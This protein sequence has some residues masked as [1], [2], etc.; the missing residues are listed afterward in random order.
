MANHP[1]LYRGGR[2]PEGETETQAHFYGSVSP[3]KR[4]GVRY[5][6]A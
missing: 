4:S 1:L 5:D 6:M 2:M 3:G